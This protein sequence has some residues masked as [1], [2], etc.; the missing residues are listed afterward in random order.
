M[1]FVNICLLLFVPF[2][3]F[4]QNF[5]VPDFE[6]NK[7]GTY[8]PVPFIEELEKTNNYLQ[9]MLINNNRYYDVI[10]I[11]KNIVYSNLLFHD[12]YAIRPDIAATFIFNDNNGKMELMDQNGFKYIKISENINYSR[13]FQ[14]YVNNHFINILN[15]FNQSI[16]QYTENGFIFNG[17]SWIIN[18]NARLYPRNNCN[19]MFYN[20]R[21]REYIG[22]HNN[23]NE[24]IFYNLVQDENNYLAYKNN[25]V[26]ITIRQ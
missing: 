12:Q 13:V 14:L 10:C 6:D 15:R 24:L 26:I 7:I 5:N 1:K 4:S 2:L 20:S 19:F 18:I 17:E 11:N 16:I 23:R 21:N 22:I 25:E 8:I 9:A 3:I